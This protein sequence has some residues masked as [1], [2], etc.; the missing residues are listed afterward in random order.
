MGAL[1]C[2]NS[3]DITWAFLQ[4]IEKQM[5]LFIII[6]KKIKRKKK[7]KINSVFKLNLIDKIN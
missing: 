3:N 6:K 1:L 5:R 4:P 2:T 7:S